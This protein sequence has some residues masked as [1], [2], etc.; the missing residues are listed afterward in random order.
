MG[1]ASQAHSCCCEQPTLSRMFT[2]HPHV[3][4][5]LLLHFLGILPVL[6]ST[7]GTN[8]RERNRRRVAKVLGFYPVSDTGQ[9]LRRTVLALQLPQ[10]VQS[11]RAKLHGSSEPLLI[12]LAK[13]RVGAVVT[14]DFFSI[15]SKLHFGC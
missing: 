7:R 13:G 9:Y 10:H 5:F 8:P 1:V 3:E 11:I 4:C 15:V 2:F 14:L 6:L 12:T